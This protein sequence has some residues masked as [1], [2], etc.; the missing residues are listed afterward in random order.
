MRSSRFV[1]EVNFNVDNI[2]ISKLVETRTNSK[3]LAEYLD[4]V[5]RSFVLVLPKMS[6]YLKLKTK[7]KT[8]N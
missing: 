4:N 3:H 6:G 2:V 5:I 7:I 1:A 8:I